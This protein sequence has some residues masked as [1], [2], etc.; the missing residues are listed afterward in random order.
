MEKSGV[1]KE[2]QQEIKERLVYQRALYR[3]H[4]CDDPALK[5]HFESII[6][7]YEVKHNIGKKHEDPRQQ[8]L[9]GFVKEFNGRGL[10]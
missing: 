7:E 4:E 10:A 1:S 6:K 5:E 2:K 9:P 3:V 8:L